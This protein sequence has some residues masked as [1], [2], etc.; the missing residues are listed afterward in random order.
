[1]AEVE[2]VDYHQGG[3]P[4]RRPVL[5][6]P[7][8]H[9]TFD[10]I[11]LVDVRNMT[12]SSFEERNA[13]AKEI[14]R[15]CSEVGFFYAQN[16]PVPQDVI[17]EAFEVIAEFFSQPEEVK[18]E[19][20]IHKTQNYRGFEPLFETKLDP[21]SRGDM[22]ESFL[23]G[24]DETDPDQNLPFPPVTGKPSP[25]SWPTNNPR[26]RTVMTHYYNYLHKFSK[27][28]SRT[29]ALA[30]DLPETFFDSMCEFPSAFVRPLHYPPQDRADG[31]EPGIAAHTDFACFTVLCQGQVEALE[32]LNKNGIWVPAPPI[33]RTF[34]I[35]IADF[36]QFFTNGRFASTVHRVVNKT[37]KER[38]SIPFFFAFD[39][40]LELEVVPSCRE[41]GID[42]QK[43]KVGDFI[44]DRLKLSRYK[45]P[46]GKA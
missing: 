11:P 23:I 25:N 38:Y 46:G 13:V 31:E 3:I 33:P 29:F 43:V 27:Q 5:R 12:S 37:G 16:H 39:E 6:G 18:A 28:L 22:K 32:V 36:M 30:L 19:C 21:K 14:G 20:H 4:G 7:K 45:H 26:F 10:S 2:Y 44:R 15:V 8:A 17:D 35:N 9:E 42:Y 34:V 40:Q 41:E 24:P 1:M